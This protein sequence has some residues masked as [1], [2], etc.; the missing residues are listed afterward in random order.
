[1]REFQINKL[2]VAK[3]VDV[4]KATEDLGDPQKIVLLTAEGPLAAIVAN[5]LASKYPDLV[6]IREPA[7]T[8]SQI[9]K[10]RL[11]LLGPVRTI[12]QVAGSLAARIVGKLSDSRISEICGTHGLDRSVASSISVFPVG[13]VN[14]EDTRGMLVALQPSVVL[15]YGTRI[16]GRRT[17]H[18]IPAPFINYHAGINPKYRGQHP[19]YWALVSNDLE[20]AGI[21]VHVIDEGVD[22]GAVLY[23]ANVRFTKTDNITTYPYVQ[24]GVALPFL[25][26]AIDD[27][28]AGRMRPRAVDLPNRLWFPPTIWQ[29]LWNGIFK[30]VW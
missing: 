26:Q 21:T 22:T 5:Y 28:L 24:L 10:R 9:I 6:V 25:V 30:R 18:S 8:K 2:G 16:I 19:A 17:L 13:S 4:E 11:R 3:N 7:E 12:G 20:H 1:M 27:V 23:Q 29:Y 14:S 15:V